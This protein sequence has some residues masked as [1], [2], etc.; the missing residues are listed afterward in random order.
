MVSQ[1]LYTPMHTKRQ[2]TEVRAYSIRVHENRILKPGKVQLAFNIPAYCLLK[3]SSSI[4]LNFSLREKEKYLLL[5]QKIV[6][7]KKQY[8]FVI[9]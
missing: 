2:F 6:R 7:V 8:D 3:F 4:G 9:F 5:K 1:R